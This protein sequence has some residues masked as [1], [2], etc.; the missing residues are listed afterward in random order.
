[1]HRLI[2]WFTRNGVAANI[3]M[4]AIVGAGIYSGLNKIVLQE[5]PDY[6]SRTISVDVQYRGSTPTE[7]E[8]SIVLRL[9]ENLFDIE[10][11][12]EIDARASSNSGIVSL[13]I[14]DN[15]DMNR[16]LDEVKNRVDTIRTFPIEAERPRITLRNFEERVITVVIAGDLSEGD[17]K[18]LGENIRD[19]IGSLEGISLTTLKAVRPYEIAI[20]VPEATLREY[21]I[22]FDTVVRA[23]RNHSVDL[24]AGSI[25]TDGGNILLRT[26]QQ[27]YTQA[28]FDEIPVVVT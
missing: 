2:D 22:S 7:I 17:M 21:G 13:T 26:S 3:L 9:E 16:A 27:A 10:G 6:P 1:M 23:V 5:F 4:V 20:E 18:G 28:D 11:V 8:E 19:E 24:S 12:E 25:K 14:S 15:Y